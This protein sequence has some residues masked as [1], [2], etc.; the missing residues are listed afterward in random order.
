MRLCLLLLLLWLRFAAAAAVVDPTTLNGKVLFGYQGW[1]DCPTDGIEGSTWRSWFRGDK[2]GPANLTVDLYPDLREF[3]PADL[4]PVP[5]FTI[6]SKAAY[7]FSAKNPHIVQRHF[8][9][10]R[11][12]ELDGVLVQRFVNEIPRMRASHDIVLRNIMAAAAS[13]GRVFAIEYD[14]S[15]AK[16]ATL[17]QTLQEDWAYLVRELKVTAHPQYLHHNRLP[18]VSV[19]G[20]GLSDSDNHP[21]ADPAAAERLIS[22]FQNGPDPDLHVTYMGGVPSRWR[23]LTADAAKQPAW[24]DAYRQMD[25]IQPWTVG[26]YR[27]LPGVAQWNSKMLKPDLKAVARNGHQQLYM[28]VVFPGFSWANLTGGK[29]NFAPRLK[30]DFLWRQAYNAF[31]AGAPALKMAMFDEVNEGT[32]MFKLAPHRSDAPDQGFWL[33]LDADG[34]DLPS[35]YYLQLAAK[36]TRLFH[37]REEGIH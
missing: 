9:W 27:D 26:R 21:P 1:F 20:I 18:I 17:L 30:G 37:G 7:L 12:Y 13:T 6:G 15:G 29:P 24:A 28:P 23:T 11:Q 16:E 19:W 31:K 25:V 14:V 22:W 2:P 5:G 34:K 4:C 8:E 33:T 35:D 3:D 32:A 10:M 36:I